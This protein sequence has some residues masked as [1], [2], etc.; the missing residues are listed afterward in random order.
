MKAVALKALVVAL[1]FG[2]AI[3][4]ANYVASI[5]HATKLE[6]PLSEAE[7]AQ[8]RSRPMTEANSGLPARLVERTRAE[9]LSDSIG[10]SWFWIRVAQM[11]IFPC[12][13]VFLAGLCSGALEQ[14]RIDREYYRKPSG[15]RE[16]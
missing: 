7:M 2:P 8:L 10:Q 9:W 15:L 5:E 13:G 4:L 12:I 6:R 1:L 14:R 16:G 3:S 11:S